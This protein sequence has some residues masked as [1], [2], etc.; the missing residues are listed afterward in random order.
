M[1]EVTGVTGRMIYYCANGSLSSRVRRVTGQSVDAF[2]FYYVYLF[3][4]WCRSVPTEM[5]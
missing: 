2:I 5:Y 1:I 4:V 3:M